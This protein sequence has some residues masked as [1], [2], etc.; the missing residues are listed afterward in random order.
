MVIVQV[1]PG[2]IAG[3]CGI[4]PGD[5]LLSVNGRELRDYIDYMYELASEDVILAV[6]KKDGSLEEIEIE[7]EPDE[8]LGIAF[9]NDGFGKRLV[10]RNK[11]VFCFVDQMPKGM[12]KTLYVKDDDWRMSFLMGSYITL[13]NM[14]EEEV[15]RIIEQRISPLYVSVHAY[16]DEMRKRLFGNE[17]AAHTFELIKR[18]A[19]NGIRLH[20]Q[21]VMCEGLNDGAVLEETIRELYALY[22]GV[23]SVAVV[24]AGLTK[25]REK[26]ERLAP[27]GRETAQETIKAVEDFQEEFLA[28]NKE[29]RFVFA[30]DE[31]YIKAEAALPPYEAYEDFAQIENGVGLVKMFEREAEEAFEDFS[32]REP[33]YKKAGLITGTDFHPFLK[34]IAVRLEKTFGIAVNVY[35]VENEFFGKSVTVTG[36]LT[37]SDVARQVKPQGEEALFLSRCCFKENENAM[38]D[39]M[40]L[41]ELE[42][43]LGVPCYKIAADGYE[44]V[45]NLFEE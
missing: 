44:L 24:P 21:I 16:D 41:E 27:V 34:E 17:N 25:H 11:C 43:A 45:R 22:P 35:C 33:R 42:S 23:Q 6:R 37:G 7:K 8:D 26:L 18:F 30:S 4:S 40:S 12:R 13:T 36:L 1:D 2:S 19:K 5:V 20:T 31:M 10:C 32:G 15:G 28:D 9:E 3:E 29:T 39:G 38:L 14:S